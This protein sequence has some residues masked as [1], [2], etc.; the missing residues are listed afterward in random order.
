ME[1]PNDRAPQHDTLDKEFAA[2]RA[3]AIDALTARNL[4]EAE[5][6]LFAD[7]ASDWSRIG[8]TEDSNQEQPSMSECLSTF[9][10]ASFD[11]WNSTLGE[12]SVLDK[13]PARPMQHTGVVIGKWEEDLPLSRAASI[14]KKRTNNAEESPAKR[15]SV[16]ATRKRNAE[17]WMTISI[18]DRNGYKIDVRDRSSRMAPPEMVRYNPGMTYTRGVSRC[19]SVYDQAERDRVNS[20]NRQ[21]LLGLARRRII[22][23]VQFGSAGPA[24]FGPEIAP[25]DKVQRRFVV[26][27]LARDA[28]TK[29][30]NMM[31]EALEM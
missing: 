22:K 9:L 5:A 18:D 23:F 19:I 21:L 14:K 7:L 11:E 17:A 16:P 24:G 31:L 28:V 27:R 13:P 12:P 20:F 3:P 10:E 6:L 25:E 15:D 2:S 8:K 1:A 26:L 30:I 4:T 29:Q